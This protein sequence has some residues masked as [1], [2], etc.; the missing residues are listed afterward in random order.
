VLNKLKVAAA[1]GVLSSLAVGF[2]ISG[3]SAGASSTTN[4]STVQS[5]S[6][7]K[8]MAALVAAAKAEGSINVITLPLQGWANYGAIMKDFTKKYGIKINDE[9]PNG[10]SQDEITAVMNDKG[11][12]AAPDVL[13]VGTS[14][15]VENAKLLAPYKVQTWSSIPVGTKSPTGRW[16][17]DYGGYVSI[18]CNTAKITK[19]PTSFAQLTD[20]M[21]KNEVGINGDPTQASAAFSAVFAAAL[22]NG[23]SFSNIEPGVK[24]FANLN[25]IGN[26]VPGGS[27]ATAVSGT[28]P[29]LIW[30]D[31]L[32][33]GIQ[34]NLKTWK[35]NIPT[36]A[37]YAAYYTQAIT[38]DAPHPAAAR[39]WEE[40]LYSTVG[41]NLFLQ[42]YARPIELAAMTT[43]GTVN[44][45][46]LKLLPA[47]P[48]GATLYPTLPQLAAAKATV[49]ANWASEV[50]AAG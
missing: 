3:S 25:K 7:T 22:A 38:A 2:S 24:F 46:Y 31:Y 11:R 9:N 12:A 50:G 48:K 28:T 27:A 10:S 34:A 29:I 6:G 45:T 13:D 43:A 21:Y 17:D 30:W 32:Q 14:Y 15:A 4:W 26:Y 8:G 5:V 37:S 42:G 39:L 18:G 23:G 1:A 44:Q 47:A 19:C 33:N 36:D 35:V 16:F 49:S 41:Q 20:P 40:Y